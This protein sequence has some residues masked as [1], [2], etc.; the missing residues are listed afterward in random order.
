MTT[1]LIICSGNICRSPMAEGLLRKFLAEQGIEDVRVHSAGTLD[2]EGAP[3]SEPGQR[4]CAEAFGVDLSEHRSKGLTG[5][6]LR[7]ADLVL[8]MA[9]RHL[10]AVERL[11]PE[12][13]DKSFLLKSYAGHGGHDLDVFDPIGES[14]ERYQATCAELSELLER[15]VP[16]IKIFMARGRVS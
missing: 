3:A 13:R 12:A 16:K 1:I 9:D 2:I 5:A 8:C 14:Y 15:C 4:A 10:W 6:M 7:E 11:L